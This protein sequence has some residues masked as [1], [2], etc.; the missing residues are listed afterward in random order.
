M[1]GRDQGPY[2]LPVYAGRSCPVVRVVL[3]P[4]AVVGDAALFAG[5][6]AIAFF[7]MWGP[8]LSDRSP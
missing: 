4:F 5:M 6:T 7:P 3:T 2:E 1:A 8:A